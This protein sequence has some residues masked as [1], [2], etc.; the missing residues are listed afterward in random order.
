[1]QSKDQKRKTAIENRKKNIEKYQ[2]GIDRSKHE[3]VK[4]FLQTK[5]ERAKEDIKNTTAK[6]KSSN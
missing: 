5:I 4:K 6:M 2:N 1:M 3:N